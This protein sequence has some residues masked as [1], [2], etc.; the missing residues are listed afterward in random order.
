MF[1]FDA[2]LTTFWSLLG[3][4]VGVTRASNLA[5]LRLG[6]IFGAFPLKSA[7]LQSC[8]SPHWSIWHR[9]GTP[10]LPR[11]EDPPLHNHRGYCSARVPHRI[12][13][14]FRATRKPQNMENYGTQSH[15]N[16]KKINR[17]PCIWHID[18]EL[19]GCPTN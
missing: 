2:V 13:P 14:V 5:S 15:R 12:F 3:D 1:V 6:H 11:F 19:M 4:R 10:T 8:L 9:C 7:S 18:P 17:P 16:I